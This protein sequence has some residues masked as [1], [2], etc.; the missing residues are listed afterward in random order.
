M[1]NAFEEALKRAMAQKVDQSDGPL[2]AAQTLAAGNA[3][4]AAAPWALKLL[5]EHTRG[6]HGA[7]LRHFVHKDRSG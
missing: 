2:T 5:G 3:E 4:L 6:R 1:A 7:G